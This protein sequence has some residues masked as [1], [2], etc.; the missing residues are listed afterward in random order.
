MH[1]Y[2]IPLLITI[3]QF[4]TPIS[5]SLSGKA[6]AIKITSL[7]LINSYAIGKLKAKAQHGLSIITPRLL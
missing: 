3:H 6:I 5:N 7:T 1:L 2:F 4:L